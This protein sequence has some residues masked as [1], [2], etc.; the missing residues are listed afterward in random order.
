MKKQEQNEFFIMETVPCMLSQRTKNLESLYI[1]DLLAEVPSLEMT[2]RENSTRSKLPRTIKIL[3]K[4][5]L[6]NYIGLRWRKDHVRKDYMEKVQKHINSQTRTHCIDDWLVYAADK[7]NLFRD[8]LHLAVNY[9]DRYLSGMGMTCMMIASK[10]QES[11]ILS[12]L[13]YDVTTP[14]AWSFSER[15][16]RAAQAGKKSRSRRLECMA[17]YLVEL[18]LLSYQMLQF[19]PSMVAASA[20][21]LAQQI[22]FP[23]KKPR[24][25]TLQHYSHYKP[26]DLRGCVLAVQPAKMSLC[27]IEGLPGDRTFKFLRELLVCKED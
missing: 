21:F 7:L 17:S 25:A 26:S 2:E 14:T 20:V 11:R 9:L 23:G 24:N 22:L 19:L 5:Y 10:Y 1:R 3:Q 4:I 12:Y 16:V 8:T 15:F 6:R 13:N 27:C 18:S